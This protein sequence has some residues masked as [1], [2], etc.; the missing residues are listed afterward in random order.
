MI[1]IIGFILSAVYLLV[2]FAMSVSLS[3]ENNHSIDSVIVTI[4][5]IL[6]SIWMFL[7]SQGM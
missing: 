4:L 2:A 6:T 7:A 3:K 5:F 1:K